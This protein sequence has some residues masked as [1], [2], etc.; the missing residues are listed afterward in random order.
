MVFADPLSF[1]IVGIIISLMGIW[2]LWSHP[3]RWKI[4]GTICAIIGVA[5]NVANVY[6]LM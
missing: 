4:A 2:L 3:R 6:Q 5:I 1:M